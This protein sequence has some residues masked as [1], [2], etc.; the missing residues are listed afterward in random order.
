MEELFVALKGRYSDPLLHIFS[1]FLATFSGR[2]YQDE[3]D[4]HS[5]VYLR[6]LSF[7][8]SFLGGQAGCGAGS[9]LTVTF[10]AQLPAETHTVVPVHRSHQG[11]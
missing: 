7:L 1:I 5:F 4:V 6:F 9:P 3:V 2:I 11:L 8:L 10:T